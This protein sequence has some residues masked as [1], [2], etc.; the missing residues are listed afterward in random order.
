[1]LF[2]ALSS[3]FAPRASAAGDVAPDWLRAAAQEKLPDYDKDTKAV[4]LLDE[5]Q[6]TVRDNGDIETLHRCAIRLLLPQARQDY[7]SIAI[8]FDKDTKIESLKAWTIESNGHEVAVGEKDAVERGLFDEMEYTDVRE[9]GLQFP[10]ANPGNVVGYEYVQRVRPYVFEDDWEFQDEVP[11]RK[12]RF[13]LQLPPGW[14]YTS[15]W[16]NYPEQKPVATGSN[17][18]SWEIDDLPAVEIE[19]E[20]PAWRSLAGWAGL[21]YFPGDPAVRAK[22]SGSWKDV[23]L[24]YNDLTQSRRVAS[25]EIKQKVAEL[26]S[27]LSDPLAKMLALTEYMQR[28]IRYYAVEIGIGGYQP[29]PAAE[30]FAHQFGDC[31]DKA[32][33]LSSMLHEI[34]INSYYVLIHT[35][36]GF[37]HSTYPSIAFNH[38]ILAIRLPDSISDATLY[39]VVNDAKLGRLLIFDPTN[40]HVPLGY[41]PYY[42]QDSDG[43]LAAP[44]GGE[45]IHMPL[46]PP[47]SNRLLRSA[48]FSLSPAGDLSG[49]VEELEWGGPA[50]QQ[51]EEFLETQPAKRAEIFEHFLGN[52]LNNFAL[53]GASLGNLEKYDESFIINYKFFSQGYANAAGDLLFVR[54]RVVGDKYTNYLRLLTQRKPRKYPIEFDEA[55]LQSDVFDITVPPGYVVDGLPKPVQADCPYASYKSET[56]FADGA[57]HYTR[58]FQVK[59]VLVPVDKLPEIR[60]FL[61]QVAADQ[62]SAAVLKKTVTP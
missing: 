33:L 13:T 32:T 55:T 24:W 6:T 9:K 19:P 46:L 51:R 1:V 36:R 48:K 61:Q 39:S 29:H 62:E 31:K 20:M 37:V 60:D 21:K 54:P 45:L 10:E 7:G 4:I 25:P 49:E 53:T 12:A 40:E 30:V 58:T 18:Y 8:D 44:D 34:G 11:V 16:F 14:E 41:L 50:A 28:N 15:S 43:L 35:E 38:A 2:L 3:W 23:G 52:F 59:D 17:N 5:T 26:T 22:S 47:A 57:L 42:L 56:T 27:G